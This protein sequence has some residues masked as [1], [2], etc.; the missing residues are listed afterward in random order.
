MSINLKPHQL[1]RNK[2]IEKGIN[3]KKLAELTEL[4]ES[5]ISKIE[6]GIRNISMNTFHKLNPILNFTEEEVEKIFNNQNINLTVYQSHTSQLD[7]IFSYKDVALLELLSKTDL[8]KLR[9]Y[10]TFLASEKVSEE[11]KEAINIVV[12]SLTSKQNH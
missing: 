5:E 8:I 12:K 9:N 11:D 7:N 3:Q 4:S 2:R 6:N 10:I 1:I